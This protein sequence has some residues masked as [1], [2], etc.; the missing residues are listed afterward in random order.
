MRDSVAFSSVL[1]ETEDQAI[2]PADPQSTES[3]VS[4]KPVSINLVP[5]SSETEE[6]E[7]P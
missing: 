5:V 2:D 6:T 4:E 1:P 7:W 3:Q